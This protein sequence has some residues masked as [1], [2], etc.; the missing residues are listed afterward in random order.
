MENGFADWDVNL[1]FYCQLRL[2]SL[3]LFLQFLPLDALLLEELLLVRKWQVGLILFL[4]RDP[5]IADD[6]SAEVPLVLSLLV[7]FENVLGDVWDM[8]T[9]VGLAGKV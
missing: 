7:A 1:D 9:S 2:A 6:Q 8:L 4:G 3:K 5:A